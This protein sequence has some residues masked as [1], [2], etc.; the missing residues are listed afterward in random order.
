MEF[1]PNP[2]LNELIS[3]MELLWLNYQVEDLKEFLPALRTFSE[4]TQDPI[5]LAAA[6][7]YSAIVAP[8]Y[9]FDVKQLEKGALL[10]STNDIPYFGMKTNNLLGIFYSLKADYYLSLQHYLKSVHISEIHPEFKYDHV[11]L[12]NVGNIFVWLNENEVA[13]EYLLRA[14]ST[15]MTN[16]IDD[17]PVL[18][19]VVINLIECYS[20]L[21][22]IEN[23]RYW[24]D[25]H[26]LDLTPEDQLVFDCVMLC[27]EIDYEYNLQNLEQI[28]PKI[29]EFIEL[30]SGVDDFIYVFRASLTLLKMCIELNEYS[31]S[32][33]LLLI[34]EELRKSSTNASFDFEFA[35]L[36]YQYFN[37]FQAEETKK[38]QPYFDFYYQQSKHT[39][40]QL[41][42]TYANS[43]LVQL[44]LDRSQHEN[45]TVLK[46]NEQLKK[47]VEKDI[48][49]DLYNKVSS[50]KYVKELLN[51]QNPGCLQ[52]LFLM[53]IDKFKSVNDI[54]GHDF[55]D[56][57]IV[58]TADILKALPI[59]DKIAGRFGGDEF[60]LF[61]NNIA[62]IEDIRNIADSLLQE[63]KTIP[64]PDN[65]IT[66]ITYSIGIT[67]VKESMDF[68]Q[69]FKSS[70]EALYDA[71]FHG[72]NQ[73]R[74]N[75]GENS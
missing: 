45:T 3:E 22:Q 15:Y 53:D 58:S 14:H 66:N 43:L 21:H 6:Y 33:K 67:I 29:C 46:Q 18:L 20:A 72:R 5:G 2:E 56:V 23:A 52:A 64:L 16:E 62:S 28:T 42:V 44:E 60:L 54:Y 36:K 40:E 70:D 47:D 7:Y 12:N 50:E 25:N 73:Y 51:H 31:L 9:D 71:K 24:Y 17:A 34:M 61:I 37:Q 65:Q 1:H 13:I 35:D 8:E 30:V 48:F 10:C 68:D 49:T 59:E 69:A 11:V 75:L 57:V 26:H 4:D 27:G 55:G 63:A 38:N 41:K 19:V 74:I 39:I 32:K